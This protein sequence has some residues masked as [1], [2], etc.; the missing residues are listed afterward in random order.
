MQ[1]KRYWADTDMTVRLLTNIIL[2]VSLVVLAAKSFEPFPSP[3][4]DDLRYSIM[5]FFLPM[6]FMTW[7]IHPL[8]YYVTD[9]AIAIR[10]PLSTMRLSREDIEEVKVIEAGELGITFRLFAS[11]GVF[12]YLGIYNSSV[13]GRIQMWCTNKDNLVMIM[14]RKGIIVISPSDPIGFVTDYKMRSSSRQQ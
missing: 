5:F 1:A 14:S 9:N 6:L 11:G 10:R 8:Y 13:F 3:S 4:G 2:A 7:S 12:G